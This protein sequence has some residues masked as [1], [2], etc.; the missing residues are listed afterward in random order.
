MRRPVLVAAMGVLGTTLL[1]TYALHPTS[2]AAPESGEACADLRF[3]GRLYDEWLTVSVPPANDMQE[4]GNATYPACPAPPGCPADE[5]EGFGATDVYYV[6]DVDSDKAVIGLRE[7]THTYVLFVRQD[8][9]P[10]DLRPL[11]APGL[12]GDTATGSGR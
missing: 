8:L 12:I 5:F 9:D 1:L 7:G 6:P 4:V 10:E 3:S 2:C 11:V